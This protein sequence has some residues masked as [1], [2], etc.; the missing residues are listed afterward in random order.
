MSK[1]RQ[2]LLEIDDLTWGYDASP[3]MLYDN[4]N[5]DLYEKDFCFIVGKSGR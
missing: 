2:K 3:T 5:L 4:F 1:N